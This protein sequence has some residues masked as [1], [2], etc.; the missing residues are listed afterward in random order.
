MNDVSEEAGPVCLLAVD[1]SLHEL[2]PAL[3]GGRPASPLPEQVVRSQA[4]RR[5]G[6]A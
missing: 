4:L 1:G 5:D 3:S 6:H 2:A